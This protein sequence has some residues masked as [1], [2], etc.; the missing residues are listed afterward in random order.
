[1]VEACFQCRIVVDNQVGYFT[2]NISDNNGYIDGSGEIA[3]LKCPF[4][5]LHGKLDILINIDKCE[6]NIEIE[7]RLNIPL[8][9]HVYPERGHHCLFDYFDDVIKE[10][11]NL[12]AVK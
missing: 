3:K 1:M 11:L 9:Y 6:K 8:E 2:F 4:L 7:K 5:I 10:F 12:L